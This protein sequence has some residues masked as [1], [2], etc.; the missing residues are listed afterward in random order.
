MNKRLSA[1]HKTF[2]RR[3]TRWTLPVLILVI[4]LLGDINSS[5]RERVQRRFDQTSGLLVSTVFSLAQDAEG[6]IWIGTAGG[7]VRYDGDQ[8]RPWA[9]EVIN[10][11]VF[12]LIAS[13]AGE[14][15]VAEGGGMLY[16]VTVEGVEPLPGPGAKPLTEVY[17]A[18]FDTAGRPWVVTEAGALHFRRSQNSWESFDVERYFP[19]EHIRRVRS[20]ANDHVYILTNKAVWHARVGESPRK[21]L[22]IMR[23]VD[24][25]EHPD[26]SL[27]VLAWQINGELVQIG[28]DG[29][30]VNRVTLLARPIDLVLRGQVL[31]ASFDRYLVSLRGDEPPDIIGPEDDLPSG[32]PL[33]VDHEGSLW[34][35]TF[36]GL[37]QYPEPETTIWNSKDGLSTSHTR[38]LA[39]T[40]EGIW[41]GTW[42]GL[43]RVAREGNVW[44]VYNEKIFT[45][46]CVDNRGVLLVNTRDEL[47]ERRNGR[48]VKH[49]PPLPDGA[50]INGCAH[51]S[52]GRL[53]LTSGSG[54][55]RDSSEGKPPEAVT[56][57]LG[58]GGQRV[59]VACVLEDSGHRLWAATMDGR[60]CHAPA[61]AIISGQPVSWSCQS[62]DDSPNAFD[63]LQLP[64]GNLWLSTNRAGIWRYAGSRWEPIPASRNLPS[65]V[66]F[67]LTTSPSGDIWLVG[68]GTTMRVAERSDTAE[69]WEVVEFLSAWEG[70]PGSGAGDLIEEPDG[71]VWLATSSGVVRVPVEARRAEAA[72]PRVK[73][74]D[75]V[76]NG[77]SVS[78][79][80][81]VRSAQL[82]HGSQV[83]L[84]FAALSYRDRGRLRY[85]YRLRSDA[86]WTDS[87]DTAPVLRFV[88][89]RAGD[90]KAEV[91][92]SLDG[93]NWTPE[94]ARLAFEVL[95]PWYLRPA[96]LVLFALVITAALY[97]AY[98]ARIGVLMRLERQRS[99]I[100][101]DLHDEMGSG[102]G[103]IGILSGLAAQ[104]D[105]EG[106][107]R[108]DLAQKIAM[109]AGELGNSLSEI[110]WALKPG[111]A[112]L[113]GLAY[114]VAERAGRLFPS[115]DPAFTTNFPEQW[116]K[117][118]L[119]LAVRRNL[120][121]ISSE[122][123]H[124][125]ARHSHAKRVT[126]GMGPGRG[127]HWRLWVADDGCGVANNNSGCSGSGMGLQSMRRRAEEISAEISWTTNNGQG[128]IVS[129][130]FD[131]RA[132]DSRLE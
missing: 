82:P 13:R 27:F 107:R 122:A 83:E 56:S 15:L 104:D 98:R 94:P 50:G 81:A 76:I 77:R 91:R 113:E 58:E 28:R 61:H 38:V 25:V 44:R 112:T 71:D 114:H 129:V 115:G 32:G 33:L 10:R 125:A 2:L 97:A 30:A 80:R 3:T 6:F 35:G 78:A 106:V 123:L 92:A 93:V 101:M 4:A 105:L 12:T 74:V 45:L 19:G 109:T 68:Q 85:Q 87:R 72:P 55:F 5:A 43:G 39:R 14:V 110:V 111:A 54:I 31:W 34:L 67:N 121:L 127:R 65:Q 26:G 103:S 131:P 132:K 86:P 53:L 37:I 46:P 100:A 63:I 1:K 119:S 47:L 36:S 18:T 21:L 96:T 17:F 99:R 128:T 102:L 90:Y 59:G 40:D 22:E 48:F 126:L 130:V 42:G 116:P 29:N 84:H 124:N 79:V 117:V 108:K 60:V 118:E 62:I 11:D 8:M 64:S 16:R 49:S 120:L 95:S 24:V 52:D 7:L 23:P 70:L 66:L 88:D 57:P 9:K 73:L 20:A 41:V 69:G 89:L 51:T 75:V